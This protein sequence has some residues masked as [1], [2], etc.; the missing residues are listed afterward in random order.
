MNLRHYLLSNVCRSPDDPVAAEP[1]VVE[2][3][4]VEPENALTGEAAPE[5]EPA[6]PVAEEPA[7]APARAA[8]GEHGNKGKTPWYMGRINEETNA[9][10]AAAARAAAAETE[11]DN[12]RA[13]LERLQAGEKSGDVPAPKPAAS[14]IDTLVLQR[15]EQLVFEDTKNG[16]VRKGQSDFGQAAFDDACRV[17]VACGLAPDD[18]VRDL[19]AVDGANASK[20]IMDLASDGERAA[21]LAS[22]NPRQRISELTRMS[23]ATA[24]PAAD[25][26]PAP[27]PA[28]SRAPTPKP[29]I[30]PHAAAPEV[31]PTTPEGNEKMSDAQFEA[32]WKAKYIRKTA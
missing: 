5:P 15:A 18:L 6:E 24:A 14:E 26:K 2:V 8:E 22:M 17:V 27:K 30:A 28:P 31:D 21:R 7:P 10:N 20:L 1:D 3:V 32:W 4:A 13:M 11:R 9:K 23:M 19:L 25:T 29:A 12:Y 16:L